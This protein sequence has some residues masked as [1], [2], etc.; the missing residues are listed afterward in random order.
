MV[1]REANMAVI[2]LVPAMTHSKRLPISLPPSVALLIT[3]AS[4]AIRCSFLRLISSRISSS[5]A[6]TAGST[7]TGTLFF[8]LLTFI[9]PPL[10][11]V[12]WLLAA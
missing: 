4:S 2:Q 11:V 12:C 8:F 3:C 5:A 1:R 10:A 6:N 7:S 9:S